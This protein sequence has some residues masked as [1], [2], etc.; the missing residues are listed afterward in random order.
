MVHSG[1]WTGPTSELLGGFDCSTLQGDFTEMQ[2]IALLEDE[3]QLPF[4]VPSRFRTLH[5]SDRSGMG[6][7]YCPWQFGHTLE[8]NSAEKESE[9]PSESWIEGGHGHISLY[10]FLS[11]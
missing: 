8:S 7:P 4:R 10:T 9:I 2:L 6:V 3:I 5:R 11:R 1:Y